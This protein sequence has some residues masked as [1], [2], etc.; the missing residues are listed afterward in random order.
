M[1]KN[2]GVNV[3]RPH[4]TWKMVVMYLTKLFLKLVLI[5]IWYGRLLRRQKWNGW[6]VS[7]LTMVRDNLR[8]DQI[9]MSIL[10]HWTRLAN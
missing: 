5:F 1:S 7:I 6:M 9:S 4:L 8:R 2:E 3:T 10:W